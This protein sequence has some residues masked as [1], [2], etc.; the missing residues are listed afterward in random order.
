[1]SEVPLYPG[2]T[3]ERAGFAVH[4]LRNE[5]LACAKGH[6]LE[7]NPSSASVAL[8]DHSRVDMLGVWY[9][10]VNFG[11]EKPNSIRGSIHNEYDFGVSEG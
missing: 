5:E 8:A 3:W 2:T 11:A 7:I 6:S 4:H 10:S 1:M 9:K